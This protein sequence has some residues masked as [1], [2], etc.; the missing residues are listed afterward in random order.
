VGT[1]YQT[2]LVVGEQAEAC[3]ALADLGVEA[4]V[5]AAGRS[6][7]AVLPREGEHG[8][9]DVDQL[10]HSLTALTR[11]KAVTNVVVDSDM[12]MMNVYRNGR[13]VHQYVSRQEILVDWFI[14]D[15]GTSKFRIGG[16]EYPATAPTPGGPTGADPDV[17]AAFGVEPIDRLRFGAVLRGELADRHE[18]L[19]AERHHR[20]I[21]EAMNLD[22]TA[23]TTAFRW[24]GPDDLPGAVRLRS[25]GPDG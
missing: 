19:F 9:V 3:S 21:L 5:V 4:W 10:A 6:R 12:V 23:L 15:D 2:L 11:G 18:Q 13:C 8:Y 1:S 16:V 17:L 22:P 20:S 14:D 24:T 25:A 7:V